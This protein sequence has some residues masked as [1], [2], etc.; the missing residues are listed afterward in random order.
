MITPFHYGKIT[1]G[2]RNLRRGGNNWSHVSA[3]EKEAIARNYKEK[4][5]T[6]YRIY[7]LRS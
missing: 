4:R 5:K 6:H 1:N 2:I 3:A 7:L